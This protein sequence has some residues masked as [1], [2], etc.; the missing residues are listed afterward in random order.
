MSDPKYVLTDR[1]VAAGE[2][3]TA[4]G[5]Y[6][7]QPS[8]AEGESTPPFLPWFSTEWGPRQLGAGAFFKRQWYDTKLRPL[9]LNQRA[10]GPAL[11]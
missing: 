1:M 8:N 11:P 7:S 10:E 4:Y 6:D 9:G 2:L 3:W 5:A